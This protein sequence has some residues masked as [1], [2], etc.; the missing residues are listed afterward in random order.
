VKVIVSPSPYDVP[1]AIKAD[2]D[3]SKSRLRILFR[4]SDR[5]RQTPDCRA[6]LLF[7]VAEQRRL[8]EITLMRLTSECEIPELVTRS[9]RD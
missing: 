5:A 7:R 9:R 3:R 2:F 6:W 4:Y 1:G 8:Y